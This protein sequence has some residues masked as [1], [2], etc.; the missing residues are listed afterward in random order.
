MANKITLTDGSV[1]N[2]PI[3]VTKTLVL[4][5]QTQEDYDYLTNTQDETGHI[6]FDLEI[7]AKEIFAL[8]LVSVT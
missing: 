1:V 3:E 5:A 7:A 2:G 6:K 4:K 8:E